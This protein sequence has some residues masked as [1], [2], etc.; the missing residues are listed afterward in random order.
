MNNVL[1]AIHNRRSVRLFK[2]EQISRG[3]L[4]AIVDAGLWAPSSHNTQPWHFTVIQDAAKIEELSDKTK[5]VLRTVDIEWVRKYGHSERSILHN[6]PTV[7]VVAGNQGDSFEPIV[8]CAA[9][10][11]NMMIAAESLGIG[12]CWNGLVRF[13]FDTEEGKKFVPLPEG[14]IPYYA[15]CFGYKQVPNGTGPQRKPDRVNFL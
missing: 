11:Q 7:I 5:A 2:S 13:F 14:C 15:I 8:D 12:S 1:E 3:E 10:I 9:A 6:A 4:A